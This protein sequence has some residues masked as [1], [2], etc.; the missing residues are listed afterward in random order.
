MDLAA[1]AARLARRWWVVAGVA[2]LTVLGAAVAASGEAD[3]HRTTIQFVLRPDSSVTTD[4]LPGTLDALKSDGPLVHTVVGVL[5][6][7]AMLRRAAADAD[8]DLGSGYAIDSTVQPG[9][10]LIDSTV[11]GPDRPLVDRLAAGYAR[12]ASNYVAASFSAYALERLSVDAEDGSTGPGALQVAILALLVGAAMG[13]ALVAAELRFEPRLRRLFAQSEGG[14]A[15]A[16]APEP[17]AQA[18]KPPAPAP[19]PAAQ[20]RKPA[21][22][23]PRKPQPAPKAKPRPEARP[24]PD[25]RPQPDAPTQLSPPRR[26]AAGPKPGNHS[27]PGS[28]SRPGARSKPPERRPAPGR[29]EDQG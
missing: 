25:P 20:A 3:E 2:A 18:P 6:S 26:P 14:Q 21:R 29:H 1:L 23:T 24:V 8:V 28:P 12:A 5:G 10:T 4:D 27:Q 13:V 16:A 17:A 7:R 22:P 9:S 15:P 19:K 11:S